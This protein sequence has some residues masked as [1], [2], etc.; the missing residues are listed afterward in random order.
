VENKLR[1]I[2]GF[3]A[4]SQGHTRTFVSDVCRND[5]MYTDTILWKWRL[6]RERIV[7]REKSLA[8]VK[9]KMRSCSVLNNDVNKF[10]NP[11]NTEKAKGVF[12]KHEEFVLNLKTKKFEPEHEDL[13]R[14]YPALKELPKA[15]ME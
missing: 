4:H 13:C 9:G 10:S 6:L 3:H 1:R 15:L 2:K 5:E 11:F 12:L 14:A 8:S 7:Q